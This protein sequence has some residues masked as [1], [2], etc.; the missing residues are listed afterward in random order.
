MTSKPSTRRTGTMRDDELLTPPELA[1]ILKV[2][3][4]DA[5]TRRRKGER[6]PH[7]RLGKYIPFVEASVGHCLDQG[8]AHHKIGLVDL[9]RDDLIKTKLQANLWLPR[10]VL[11]SDFIVSMPK[12]KTHHWTGVTLSVKNMFGIGPGC[13][14]VAE[15]CPPLGRNRR[16]H[17][18]H[19]CYCAADLGEHRS[20][21]AME[22]DGPLNSSRMDLKLIVVSDDLVPTDSML[23]RALEVES[24]EVKHIREA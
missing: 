10:T 19:M 14:D 3:L 15:E 24:S 16:K 11:A 7:I 9:N 22:G 13:H 1:R 21:H 12:V 4:S 8:K 23:V 18:R 20:H 2:P 6:L 5:R 17:S